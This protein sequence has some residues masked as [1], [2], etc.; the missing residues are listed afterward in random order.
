[1]RGRGW[2]SSLQ[3]FKKH[4]LV[5]GKSCSAFVRSPKT[6]AR[7][8]FEKRQQGCNSGSQN[9]G[10]AH[11]ESCEQRWQDWAMPV[12]RFSPTARGINNYGLGSERSGE[13]RRNAGQGGFPLYNPLSLVD[14]QTIRGAMLHGQDGWEFSGSSRRMGRLET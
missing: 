4:V 13:G 7:P 14:C 6:A 1:M 11:F 9:A 10:V 8:N 2:A 12:D 5:V 3:K